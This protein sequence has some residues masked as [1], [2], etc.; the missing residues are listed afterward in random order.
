[1]GM[2]VAAADFDSQLSRS[3]MTKAA[4]ARGVNLVICR[5]V[6]EQAIDIDGFIDYHDMY[7]YW[8]GADSAISGKAVT[9][10]RWLQ[11]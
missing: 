6:L 2:L 5:E 9:L 10:R 4:A 7:E 1:V 3:L 8:R 11:L